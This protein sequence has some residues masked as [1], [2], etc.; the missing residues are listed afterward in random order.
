MHNHAFFLTAV[1]DYSRFTWI[2]LMKHKSETRQHI[3]DFI[4]MIEVQHHSQVKI[5]RSDNGVEFLMP[6]FYSS[7]GIIHQ[8]SCVE[9]PEQ[10][11]RVERKHQHLLN[12][13]RALLFQANLPK[14]FWSYAV[15]HATYIINRIPSSVLKNKSP[16]ELLHNEKPQIEH[17]KVFGSLAYASTLLAHRTKLD[18]RCRKCIFLGYKQGVKGTILYDL[19]TKEIILSRNVTHHDHILPY[20]SSSSRTNWQYHTEPLSATTPI[21]HPPDIIDPSPLPTQNI[22]NDFIMPDLDSSLP[23]ASDSPHQHNQI[24]SNSPSDECPDSIVPVP[25]LPFTSQRPNRDK[26]LPSYLSD[27]VCNQSSTSPVTSPSGSLYP[28]SLSFFCT[29]VTSSSCIHC[30]SHTQHRATLLFRGM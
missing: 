25:D 1:D 10:N 14:T 11:G 17:L 16:Y 29:F 26:H 27:Y 6:Q 4:K 28:I 13:G 21:T 18:P 30:F 22:P 23:T 12:V 3:I 7:K 20:K 24:D 5:I 15:Q 2:T 8:T 19:H 9:T